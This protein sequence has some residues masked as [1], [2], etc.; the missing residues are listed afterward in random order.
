MLVVYSHYG[1][2]GL[3]TPYDQSRFWAV[4]DFLS[5]VFLL[6]I[7]SQC[8]T[9]LHRGQAFPQFASFINSP[10]FSSSC[11]L[12][13]LLH[14][15]VLLIRSF[16]RA[17]GIAIYAKLHWSVWIALTF[18]LGMQFFC[19]F[20]VNYFDHKHYRRHLQF[21]RLEFDTRLGMHSPR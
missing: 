13:I 3:W 1:S 2:D 16:H 9:L 15:L 18:L 8:S 12:C 7:L 21:L 10:A 17:I 14:A 19:G 20:V 5:V 4:Q 6:S 11:L